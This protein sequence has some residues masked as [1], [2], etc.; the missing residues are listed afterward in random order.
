MTGLFGLGHRLAGGANP[1]ALYAALL[2]LLAAASIYTLSPG[3]IPGP[4]GPSYI[5]FSPVRTSFYP[6]FI[7]A[8]GKHPVTVV[9]VQCALFLASWFYL[10]FTVHRRFRSH[11]VTAGFGVG[12]AGNGYLHYWVHLSIYTESLTLTAGNLLL[13]ALLNMTDR[14]RRFLPWV[15]LAGLTVGAMVSLR[16]AMWSFAPVILLAAVLF[17]LWRGHPATATTPPP[18]T[19]IVRV[20][21][22]RRCRG[23]CRCCYRARGGR[24]LRR[25]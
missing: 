2:T 11:L 13:V 6:L 3:E 24:L 18:Q 1:C 14:E 10:I 4:D 16:P 21:V 20:V 17:A 25:A 15:C 12:V 19:R 22:F 23:V 9:V 7:A 5:D 8:L